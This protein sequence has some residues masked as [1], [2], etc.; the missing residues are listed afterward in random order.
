MNF[1]NLID[2]VA[3]WPE[4]VWAIVAGTCSGV[5]LL[6]GETAKTP[7]GTKLELRE[8]WFYRKRFDQAT[9]RRCAL[10]TPATTVAKRTGRKKN[11]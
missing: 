8:G 11:G 2:W 10:G 4:W 3:G 7:S 9:F 5:A 6:R 1:E